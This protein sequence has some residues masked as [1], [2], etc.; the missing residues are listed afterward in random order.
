[1]ALS[2]AVVFFT[3]KKKKKNELHDS[4]FLKISN[5]VLQITQHLL[6]KREK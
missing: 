3:E 2:P 1:M 4:K 5:E 6:C